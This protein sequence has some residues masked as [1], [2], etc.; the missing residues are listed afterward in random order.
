LFTITIAATAIP[1]NLKI[2]LRKNIIWLSKKMKL[3]TLFIHFLPS[4]GF[5][6]ALVLLAHILKQRR[7]PTST[8]A[9]LM[10]IVFVPYIGVPLYLIFGGRKMKYMT[11]SKQKLPVFSPA[12]TPHDC[13]YQPLTPKIFR[14]G[15]PLTQGNSFEILSTGEQAYRKTMG[16]I[17]SAKHTI[18]IATF[19]LGK[20]ATG[21]A[22]IENLA[23]KASKGVRV[24]LL[25][26]ALGSTKIHRS[27]L[28]PLLNAGG[29]TA[30]FMPMLHLPFRG[31]AN[32]RN[33]RKI[34]LV[35]GTAAI[36]GGMNLADEYMGPCKSVDYW[37]DLSLHIDGPAAAQA[38][39]IFRS[40]WKF[41]AREDLDSI[42]PP[43]GWKEEAPGTLLQFMASGPDVEGDTLRDALIAALF[44]ATQRVWIVTPYFVPDDLLLEALCMAA[45]RSIDLRLIIPKRSNHRLADLAR[46]DYLSQLQE[47]GANIL[48]YR[49]RMLHAK[50]LLI[51]DV[52]AVTGSANMDMRSLLLNYEVALCIY[53][54]DVIDHLDA[55]MRV[56]MAECSVREPHRS[57]SLAVI[58]GV[59]RLFAPLL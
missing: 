14:G 10:A 41:A 44:R 15:F 57:S 31:R 54:P 32:L 53:S 19:I 55:W 20:D 40:D 47:S 52:V 2:E 39:E 42:K 9:W 1:N 29:R 56:L 23:Q 28:S 6:L 43:A 27:F 7:S 35:D 11:A 26:D 12:Q 16:L 36:I 51:D 22:I 30:F 45:R 58:E 17:Q 49:P 48:L 38:Y 59:G 33:H 25:L 21:R 24:F 34:L 37:Q 4:L 18:H 13:L 8:L 5:I 46:E 50:A 3:P